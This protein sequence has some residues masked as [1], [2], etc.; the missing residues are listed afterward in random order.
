MQQWD[1]RWECSP[2]DNLRASG[3]EGDCSIL[4]LRGHSVL[5]TLV[6]ARFSPDH[7]GK[8]YIYSGCGRG[9]CIVY[10][11]YTG[12]VKSVLSGHNSVVRDVNWSPIENE[13]IAASVCKSSLKENL[14]I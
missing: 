14:K 6:R 2:P 10:D 13:I 4:T 9:N 5:H 11:M 8:R 12:E 1:Y 3:V 7:T